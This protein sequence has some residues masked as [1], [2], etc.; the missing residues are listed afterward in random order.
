MQMHIHMINVNIANVETLLEMHEVRAHTHTLAY[1]NTSKYMQVHFFAKTFSF[2]HHI[3]KNL[4]IVLTNTHCDFLD[5]PRQSGSTLV[6]THWDNAAV[7]GL[8]SSDHLLQSAR[9]KPT[10]PPSKLKNANGVQ[11]WWLYSVFAVAVVAKLQ[12]R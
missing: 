2:T 6:P 9:A 11:L 8:S 1:K 10:S 7:Y 12:L 3:S 5:H 4:C